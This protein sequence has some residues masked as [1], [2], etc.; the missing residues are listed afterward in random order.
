MHGQSANAFQRIKDEFGGCKNGGEMGTD[1]IQRNTAFHL[2]H[3]RRK[4]QKPS[5][6]N[7]SSIH[8][9]LTEPVQTYT[10]ETSSVDRQKGSMHF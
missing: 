8:S 6:N 1:C 7:H 5:R 10:G 9:N 4:M 2:V 3:R